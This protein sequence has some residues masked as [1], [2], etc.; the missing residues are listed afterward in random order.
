[1]EQIRPF[2]NFM[3]DPF[4]QDLIRAASVTLENA[5]NQGSGIDAL[6]LL[7]E[8]LD[9]RIQVEA[10]LSHLFERQ[11]ILEWDSGR[12]M[13]RTRRLGTSTILSPLDR[14]AKATG[15]RSS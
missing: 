5:G 14:E 10:I 3:G 4:A 9:L 7:E 1:M 12:L 11:I 13:P 8:R 15:L 2:S 6:V